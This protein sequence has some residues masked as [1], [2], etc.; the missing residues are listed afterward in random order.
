MPDKEKRG[1]VCTRCHQHVVQ[2]GQ[3]EDMTDE[4]FEEFADQHLLDCP[5]LEHLRNYR[6]HGDPES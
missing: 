2:T 6:L 3:I 5:L 4:E 1:F